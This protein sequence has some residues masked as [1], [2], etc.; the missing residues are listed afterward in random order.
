MNLY[1]FGNQAKHDSRLPHLVSLI[2]SASRSCMVLMHPGH[3]GLLATCISEPVSLE[4]MIFGKNRDHL[5]LHV[6]QDNGWNWL[7]VLEFFIFS[8][9][10]SNFLLPFRWNLLLF[11]CMIFNTVW[12]FFID[13]S[14]YGRPYRAGVKAALDFLII[15]LISHSFGGKIKKWWS[16]GAGR[17]TSPDELRVES[18]PVSWYRVFMC[19]SSL[20]LV[21]WPFHLLFSSDIWWY[22]KKLYF[23]HLISFL[24][25]SEAWCT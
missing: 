11:F 23:S 18:W 12:H 21:M 16:G 6:Q 20:P 1:A 2:G 4:K 25:I 17:G 7:M 8:N 13:Y 3:S 9:K 19:C 14:L 24:W 5:S 15:S 22:I 10:Y